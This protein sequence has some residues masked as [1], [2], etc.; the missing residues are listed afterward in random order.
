[1]EVSKQEQDWRKRIGDVHKAEDEVSEQKQRLSELRQELEVQHLQVTE[2]HNKNV[3]QHEMNVQRQ[4][5]LR[6][7]EER[8][9]DD[10]ATREEEMRL[11]GKREGK[12]QRKGKR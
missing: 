12:I 6:N 1:M 7:L 9:K 3:E 10:W 4:V 5:E 8:Q 2:E 11:R